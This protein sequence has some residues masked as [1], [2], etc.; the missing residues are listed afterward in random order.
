LRQ[1]TERQHFNAQIIHWSR[2]VS[3]VLA[4]NL[5]GLQYQGL[6]RSVETPNQLLG[7]SNIF[8]AENTEPNEESCPWSDQNE[9]TDQGI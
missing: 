5:N 3:G 1:S 4:P 7:R 8:T 6:T 2:V 9:Y